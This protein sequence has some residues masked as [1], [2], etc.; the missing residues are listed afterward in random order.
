MRTKTL[1]LT[2]AVFAAGLGASMA[3]VYSVNAVGYVN[4]ALPAGYSMICN[5]LQQTNDNLSTVIPV[6]PDGTQ[7]VTWDSRPSPTGQHFNNASVFDGDVNQWFPNGTLPVGQGAFILLPSAATLTFVG[8]VKQGSLTNKIGTPYTLLGNMVPQTIG[9]TGVSGAG[10]P[11]AD[12]DQY[13][14]WNNALTPQRY[15][16]AVAYDIDA[17]QWFGPGG[18]TVP[19]PAVGQGFFIFTTGG[20]RDW[21]RNFTVN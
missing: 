8:D 21:T 7:V 14:T 9:L 4:L 2:A 12:G 11:A 19:T 16:D 5:P 20:A 1:L 18:A 3:Q 15:N 13:L 6:A 10:Y 17:Q